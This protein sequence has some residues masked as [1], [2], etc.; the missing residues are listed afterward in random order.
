MFLLRSETKKKQ[1]NCPCKINSYQSS[2]YHLKV[3][4]NTIIELC[5]TYTLNIFQLKNEII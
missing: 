5:F 2:L 1:G 3:Y 4:D